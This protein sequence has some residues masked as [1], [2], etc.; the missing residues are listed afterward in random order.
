MA[1]KEN[2][3]FRFLVRPVTTVNIGNGNLSW[4]F[5]EKIKFIIDNAE[6]SSPISGILILPT[7]IDRNIVP[8]PPDYVGYKKS[9][10]SVSVGLNIDFSLWQRSSELERLALLADNIRDSLRMIKN[11]YLLEVDRK[12]L[13][14][15]VDE[16]Q[17]ELASEVQS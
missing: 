11:R 12:K 17:A 16:A 5:E 14:K 3:K 4:I 8:P 13:Y 1:R 15:V 2:T 6:F 7:I 9:D 10:N